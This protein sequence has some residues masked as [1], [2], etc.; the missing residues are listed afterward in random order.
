MADEQNEVVVKSAKVNEGRLTVIGEGGDVVASSWIARTGVDGSDQSLKI[1]NDRIEIDG[2]SYNVAGFTPNE[3]ERLEKVLALAQPR[4]RTS[5]ST[6]A[7]A[8]VSATDSLD[9]WGAAF[10]VIGIFWG[11][12]GVLAGVVIAFQSEDIGFNIKVY[13]YAEAGISLAV[14]SVVIA[15]L[16][17]AFG[18]F[19]MAYAENNRE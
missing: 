6:S 3:R 14:S 10:K 8:P 4:T 12:V 7:K 16:M 13:P 5:T 1:V 15:L 11:V 17:T 2:V 9:T 19:A 18:V